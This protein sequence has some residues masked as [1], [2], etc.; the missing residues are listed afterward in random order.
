MDMCPDGSQNHATY[1][2]TRLWS[3]KTCPLK[4]VFER[5]TELQAAYFLWQIVHGHQIKAQT[6]LAICPSP[7]IFFCVTEQNLKAHK[8]GKMEKLL[9]WSGSE[10]VC[11]TMCWKD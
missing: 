6:S 7:S 1:N 8:E 4:I 9:N 5:H 11:V 10:W 3:G 2:M